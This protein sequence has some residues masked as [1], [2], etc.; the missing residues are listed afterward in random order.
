VIDI[1]DRYSMDGKVCVVTGGSTG[2]GSYM[3]EGFLAAGAAKVY[4]TARTEATLETKASELSGTYEGE[5]IAIVGDLATLDGVAAL[6]TALHQKEPH[7]DLLINNAGIGTGGYFDQMTVE[8]WD[9]TMDLNLRSPLFL[10]QALLD[11]L[12][13]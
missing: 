13:K 11:L 10:T 2:L 12:K 4:I 9:K 5:C 7:I 8:D 1:R 6:S 3:A